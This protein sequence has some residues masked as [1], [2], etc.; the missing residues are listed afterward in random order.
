LALW[1]QN[2]PSIRMTACLFA[3]FISSFRGDWGCDRLFR[4]SSTLFSSNT[5]DNSSHT[6]GVQEF[7]DQIPAIFVLLT[8]DWSLRTPPLQIIG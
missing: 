7:A 4:W 2:K 1:Q 3:S 5:E 8:V 6:Q